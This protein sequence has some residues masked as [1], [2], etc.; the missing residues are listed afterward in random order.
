VIKL[1][2]KQI[3]PISIKQHIRLLINKQRYPKSEIYSS[4]IHDSVKIGYKSRINRNVL[5]SPYVEIGSCTYINPGTVIGER[6]NIGKFCSIAY[7]CQIGL[8]EH[9]IK[10]LSTSPFY[11]VKKHNRN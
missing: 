7:N 1:N 2:L 4:D 8:H 9:P 6:T 11:M 10:Y 3:I 5:L